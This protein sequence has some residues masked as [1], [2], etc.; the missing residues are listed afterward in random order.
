MLYAII[1]IQ[2]FFNDYVMKFKRSRRLWI[3][4]SSM[5]MAAIIMPISFILTTVATTTMTK[6]T[7]GYDTMENSREPHLNLISTTT[8]PNT[9]SSVADTVSSNATETSIPE[10]AKGPVIPEK[11]YLVQE[12][13][14]N[15]YWVTD[16]SYNTMFLITDEGVVA[17]D[18]PPSIG[19]NY[20]KAIAEVTDK[21]VTRVIYSHAHLDDI[22]AAGMFPE[23]ATY[24][25]HQ[26]TAAELQRAT[27]L[28][29]NDSM[30][31]PVPTVTFPSNYT[32]RIGNQSLNLD[33]YGTNH[34]PGNLFIYAPNQ[35]ALM[36]VD[37]VF[38][39]WVPF[40]YLAIAEDVAGFIKAHDIALNNY[41]FDTFIGGHLTRLGTRDDVVT[42]KEF[43]S[44]LEAAA[45]KSNS[46]VQ[47]TDIAKE[48]G[49]FDN[50]WSIF[51]KYDEAVDQN[52]IDTMLSKWENRLG[53]ARDFM[54]THCFAMTQGGR[55]EPSVSA[56]LQ[57][58]TM[59][60]TPN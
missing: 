3:I 46:E 60:A 17:I 56:I 11:G 19:Q 57:N 6:S 2:D 1:F 29:I 23:N 52:C 26:E 47:F 20:L 35:K 15:L 45:A 12:I 8:A 40:A 44:D 24:I 18:A 58:S 43:A 30:I 38:P 34:M 33:Y 48:V 55:V 54:S 51:S 49:S 14:D 10:A 5:T 39:G 21:P 9:N 42:Q 7:F 59:P 25:A 13:R 27:N 16:G 32:L 4:V 36:L 37:I 22:G 53:G 28:A 41:D 31:P 50:P